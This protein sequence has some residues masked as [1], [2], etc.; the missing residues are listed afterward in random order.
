MEQ[1]T[2]QG[3]QLRGLLSL[4]EQAQPVA[5]LSETPAQ[6]EEVKP[7][8][9][10]APHGRSHQQP[11]PGRRHLVQRALFKSMEREPEIQPAPESDLA[12]PV[13]QSRI[14][15]RQQALA[16]LSKPREAQ[17]SISATAAKEVHEPSAVEA[18]QRTEPRGMGLQESGSG[19]NKAAE[20]SLRHPLVQHI[21][22]HKIAR[23]WR[24]HSLEYESKL[25]KHGK[26]RYHSLPEEAARS[27]LQSL[28]SGATA[29]KEKPPLKP[30]AL[31]QT[32]SLPEA[33][34]S[35]RTEKVH[36]ALALQPAGSLNAAD[37][38]EL[39]P[40]A[41]QAPKVE[42]T[43]E[44]PSTSA[45]A[46]SKLQGQQSSL[47]SFSRAR[48]SYEKGASSESDAQESKKAPIK[49][50]WPFRPPEPQSR[51]GIEFLEAGKY[52]GQ[53]GSLKIDGLGVLTKEGGGIYAGEV[54]H[55]C[56]LC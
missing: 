43:F 19:M 10:S 34:A 32:A 29:Q 51:L 23:K 17:A 27:Y 9:L 53:I 12:S 8:P 20:E 13:W 2:S 5:A 22:P 55:A 37:S 56:L 47:A 15:G 30:E 36:P 48:V 40:Q 28:G 45:G 46:D 6:A 50:G 3:S 26:R 54:S 33:D 42:I 39:L 14:G 31:P 24:S 35:S 18:E 7:Q 41:Q 25:E 16:T 4:P 38:E 21:S 11:K 44:E 52:E 1:Q 49:P